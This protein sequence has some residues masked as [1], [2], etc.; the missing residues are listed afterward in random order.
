MARIDRNT[1]ELN[2]AY[3]LPVYHFIE[4]RIDRGEF[5][6]FSPGEKNN[7]A[8][9]ASLRPRQIFSRWFVDPHLIASFSASSASASSKAPDSIDLHAAIDIV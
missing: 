5:V 7:A 8:A 9:L 2:I 3:F 6:C 4:K 1:D